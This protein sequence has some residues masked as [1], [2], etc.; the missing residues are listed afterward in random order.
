MPRLIT[1]FGCFDRPISLCTLSLRP[2]SGYSWISVS[3]A[4]PEQSENP[5]TGKP[6]R[7]TSKRKARNGSLRLASLAIGS[8]ERNLTALL[9]YDL[10]SCLGDGDPHRHKLRRH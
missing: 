10:D 4:S 8:S 6:A 2:P 3:E 7:F 5:P 1:R 9:A